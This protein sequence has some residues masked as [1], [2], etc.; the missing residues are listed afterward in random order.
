M[1]EILIRFLKWWL[2]KE[3]WLISFTPLPLYP[4]ERAPGTHCIGGWEGPRACLNDTVKWELFTLLGLE[5]RSL[6]R[7]A[8]SQSLYRC[9]WYFVGGHGL[10]PIIQPPYMCCVKYNEWSTPSFRLYAAML[11]T[12][13]FRD[14]NIYTSIY[15]YIYISVYKIFC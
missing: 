6:G 2:L 15:I 8:R 7:S 11:S 4:W 3:R 10:R 13:M 12:R 5:L 1:E 9:G 14:A